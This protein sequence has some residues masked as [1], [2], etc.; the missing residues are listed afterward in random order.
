[1]LRQ[2]IIPTDKKLVLDL[3]EQYLNQ[4][5]EVI[6]FP[7]GDAAALESSQAPEDKPP[8]LSLFRKFRGRY[9]GGFNREE[10]YDR[11]IS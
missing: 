11:G 9:T 7:I 1:M 8:D 5:V 10:C 2:I 6:V 3:P 4:A